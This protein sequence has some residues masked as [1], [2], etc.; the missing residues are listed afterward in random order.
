MWLSYCLGSNELRKTLKVGAT[1]YAGSIIARD[2]NKYGHAIPASHSTTDH[3]GLSL[4][5]ATYATSAEGTATC[6]ISP[7]T[8]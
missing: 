2:T 5:A 3:L 4:D 1:V 8:V 7:L 6:L